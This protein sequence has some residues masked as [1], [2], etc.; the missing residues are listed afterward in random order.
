MERLRVLN[1]LEKKVIL[2]SLQGDFPCV[3]GGGGD[4]S[5]QLVNV[6][7]ICLGS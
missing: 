4:P 2:Y 7:R 1:D 6:R 3:S 5:L